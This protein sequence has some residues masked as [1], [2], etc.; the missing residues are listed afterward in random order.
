MIITKTVEIK[1][2]VSNMNYWRELGYKFENPAPRWGI[3][4][5]IEVKVEQL[6]SKSCVYV[7]CVCDKCQ[8]SFSNRVSRNTDICYTCFNSEKM[9]GNTLGRIK[10]GKPLEKMKGENHPRWNPN[11]TQF[12]EYSSKVRV[13]S[14]QTYKENL[15]IINPNNYPRTLCGVEDGY[16]LDHIISIKYGFDNGISPEELSEISNLQILPWKENRDKSHK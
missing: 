6:K 14:E 13:L 10:K 8:K 5:T 9:K 16:Q 1:I 2:S 12:K 15:D 7:E 3:V 4:P 11:K